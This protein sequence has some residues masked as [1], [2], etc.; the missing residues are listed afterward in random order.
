MSDMTVAELIERLQ[1]CPDQDAVVKVASQPDYPLAFDIVS[2][3][4][5]FEADPEELLVIALENGWVPEDR[6]HVLGALPGDE[7]VIEKAS[8]VYW[9]DRPAMADTVWIGLS[10]ANASAPHGPYAPRDAWN[11]DLNG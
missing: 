5:A 2:V 10:E 1:E 9:V 3:V 8:E 11:E 6:D 4:A 7:E